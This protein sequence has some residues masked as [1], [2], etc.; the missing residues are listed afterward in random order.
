MCAHVAPLLH[1]VF[2]FDEKIKSYSNPKLWI[3][4]Y[5]L[6][7]PQQDLQL[8]KPWQQFGVGLQDEEE[9]LQ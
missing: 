7:L 2:L 9:Y 3:C 8:P 4:A 5:F 1:A 6:Q